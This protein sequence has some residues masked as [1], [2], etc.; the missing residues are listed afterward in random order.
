[1]D[2]ITFHEPSAPDPRQSLPPDLVREVLV[3][4]LPNHARSAAARLVRNSGR[5]LRRVPPLLD[6]FSGREAEIERFLAGRR[7][8]ISVIEHF[9]C[10]PYWSQVAPAS[11]CTVLDLHNIESVL[12]S[13]CAAAERSPASVAHRLFAGRYRSLERLWLPRFDRVLVAS[14]A[15]ARQIPDNAHVTV[16]PNSIPERPLL[17][18]PRRHA[19]AFSGNLEYHPNIA[20]VRWFTS[21]VWP[22]LRAGL[23]DLEWRLIGRNPGA[24]ARYVMGDPRIHLTGAVEDAVSELASVRV[25]IVPLLAGSGTRFKILEAWAAA[26]PVVSTRLGAEGLPVHGMLLADSPEE[27]AGAVEKLLGDPEFAARLGAEGRARYEAEFTWPAAWR[28]LSLP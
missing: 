18:G 27:F 10:A 25:A 6:R 4:D 17:R 14:G 2:L 19:V 26:T 1:V 11:A 8:E 21:A 28:G 22:R 3:I 7:Y 20:A 13:R 15:D 9:W 16:Y 5:L 23:P 24:V 12:H